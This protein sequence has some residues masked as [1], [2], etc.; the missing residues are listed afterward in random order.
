MATLLRA[1][2]P[3]YLGIK[4]VSEMF[5]VT[6][7]ALRKGVKSGRIKHVIVGHKYMIDVDAFKHQLD[8]GENVLE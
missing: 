1:F 7:Y 8:S 5:G 6:K 2:T 3:K 4:E